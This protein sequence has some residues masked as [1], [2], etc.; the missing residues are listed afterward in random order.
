MEKT[1]REKNGGILTQ[2]E[3]QE[4]FTT[5][6]QGF[7]KLS[8]NDQKF[9][10]NEAKTK[11][12]PKARARKDTKNTELIQKIKEDLAPSLIPRCQCLATKSA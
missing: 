4:I 1:A 9:Y 6:S 12:Q 10:N 8:A 7:G 3:R 11:L 2:K 5:S